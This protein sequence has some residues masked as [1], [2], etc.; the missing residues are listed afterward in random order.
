MKWA[1]R[2]RNSLS[3]SRKAGRRFYPV[4]RACSK[5]ESHWRKHGIGRKTKG[6]SNIKR[7]GNIMDTQEFVYA[8]F[9]R[10]TPE[11]LWEALTNGDF[12]EKYWF[13]FRIEFEL[14]AGGK[15]RIVPPEGMEE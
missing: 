15:M 6:K 13:G 7:K 4:S 1:K 11:K 9:I 10:T 12:S 14:K 3:R 5:P 8:M 2:A